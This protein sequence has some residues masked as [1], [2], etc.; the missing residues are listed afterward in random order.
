MP[1]EA[2]LAAGGFLGRLLADRVPLNSCNR[3]AFDR[4]TYRLEFQ[5]FL[6]VL[7]EFAVLIRCLLF[8]VLERGKGSRR[9]LS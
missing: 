1:P 2:A 9:L 7:H 6:N 4:P 3:R 5:F 8:E